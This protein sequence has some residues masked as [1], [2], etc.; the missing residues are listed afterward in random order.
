M[1]HAP[2]AEACRAY[3]AGASIPCSCT[4]ALPGNLNDP[5]WSEET[6][7]NAPIGRESDNCI[8]P[9]CSEEWPLL[10][11]L[12]QRNVGGLPDPSKLLSGLKPL[13]YDS[14]WMKWKIDVLS[15]SALVKEANVIEANGA[16]E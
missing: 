13:Y 3:N 14:S 8:S 16:G 2:M 12:A 10:C 7:S 1:M 6:V 15:P 4:R 5:I 9:S 11:G